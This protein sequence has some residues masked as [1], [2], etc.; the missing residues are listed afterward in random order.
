MANQDNSNS[1]D[2]HRRVTNHK[3][4][5]VETWSTEGLKEEEQ[6]GKKEG[7]G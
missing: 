3:V 6:E 1:F 5:D 7:A 4:Y 2:Y